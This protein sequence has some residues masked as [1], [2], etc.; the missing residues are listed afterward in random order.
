MVMTIATP[1][2]YAY[3]AMSA[4]LGICLAGYIFLWK[5]TPG[6]T[7][8]MSF[9][10]R[11]PVVLTIDRAANSE[12]RLAK[13]DT[14]GTLTLPG[15]GT[16][17]KEEGGNTREVKTKSAM[18]FS[19]TDYGLTVPLEYAAILQEIR[20][21][22]IQLDD[23]NDYDRLLSLAS[24]PE[25]QVNALRDLEPQQKERLQAFLER[26]KSEKVRVWPH[27]TYSFQKISRMFPRNIMPVLIEQK[28]QNAELRAKKLAGKW[29]PKLITTVGFAALLVLVGAAIFF[30]IYQVPD[31]AVSCV[32]PAAQRGVETVANLVV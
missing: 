6:I 24:S 1:V 2:Y 15:S 29:D 3:V 18:Y 31:V 14:S 19:F 12:F 27:K 20:E 4:L 9:L 26:L 10:S 11:Q 30:R 7:F 32:A 21:S 17:I 28:I 8:L 25:A 16:L 5:F 13:E 23:Y 22:G